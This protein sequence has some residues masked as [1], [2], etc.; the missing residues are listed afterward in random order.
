LKTAWPL[1]CK[2]VGFTPITFDA[3]V[4]IFD[5]FM[6]IIGAFGVDDHATYRPNGCAAAFFGPIGD[7]DYIV[8]AEQ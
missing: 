1:L 3:A 8:I 5:T 6:P 4:S 2:K 7:R